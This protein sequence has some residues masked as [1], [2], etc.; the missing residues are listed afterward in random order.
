M[1]IHKSYA[2][3]NAVKFSQALEETLKLADERRVNYE[4]GIRSGEIFGSKE[5]RKRNRLGIR[6][7]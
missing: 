1:N 4:Q 2:S 7:V 3:E 6:V 5:T